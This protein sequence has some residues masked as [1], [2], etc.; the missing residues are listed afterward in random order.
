[1]DDDTIA[2]L[3]E[4]SRLPGKTVKRVGLTGGIFVKALVIEFDDGT[5]MRFGGADIFIRFEEA[6]DRLL[7]IYENRLKR[8]IEAM[9]RRR[10]GG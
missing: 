6:A 7:D 1:M 8:T 9:R 10:S 4:F 3:E 5:V 2:M